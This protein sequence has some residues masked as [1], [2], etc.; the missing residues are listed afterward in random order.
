MFNGKVERPCIAST[1]SVIDDLQAFVEQAES[2]PETTAAWDFSAELSPAGVRPMERITD[3]SKNGLTGRL[4][5]L[6]SRGVAG[7]SWSGQFDDFRTAPDQYAA[8]H[9]HEDDVHDCSWDV[10]VSWEV[11]SDTP[12]QALA[13]RLRGEGCEDHIPFVVKPAPTGP[14]ARAALLLPTNTYLAYANDHMAVDGPMW[15]AVTGRNHVLGGY[16]LFRHEHREFGASLYDIHTDGSGV[17]YSNWRRPIFNLRVDP[18]YLDP[19]PSQH[20]D[21]GGASTWGF[22]TDL[23][24]LKWLA[25]IGTDVDLICDQDLQ[26]NGLELLDDYKVVMT[27]SHPE[28]YT[29]DQLDAFQSYV[30]GGGRLMYL[31]GNGF[32]WVTALHPDDPDTIEVRRWG[33]TE[34][35][36]AAPGEHHLSLTGELGGLWRNRGRAPQKLVGVGF[37]AQGGDVSS[38]YRRTP[39][40]YDKSLAWIFEGVD[41][42]IIGDFG[43][44]GGSA[45][46][47]EIDCFDPTL[48]SPPNAVVLASSEDHTQIMREARENKPLSLAFA[49]GDQ[50]PDVHADIVYFSTDRGGAVFSVGS[51]A[52]SG[53]LSH[54]GGANNVARITRNVFERF[55]SDDPPS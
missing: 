18:E 12:S 31:G 19:T 21:V 14:K 13:L 41:E 36:S 29:E 27:G 15:P 20:E 9:F 47:L 38:H 10:T 45:A 37:V 8:I 6:P 22:P 52:W 2:H 53:S 39:Y 5:N 3:V 25:T 35:W 26:S 50:N 34:T 40:S 1:A 55:A 33:G 30:N 23:I 54:E 46:G 4:V 24:L 28:Y 51:I 7:V 42:E 32:Y 16:D 17:C 49:G 44:I 48:G 43:M 11:P